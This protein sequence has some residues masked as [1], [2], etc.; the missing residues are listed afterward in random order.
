M[1]YQVPSGKWWR[2]TPEERIRKNTRTCQNGL[3]ESVFKTGCATNDDEEVGIFETERCDCT[4]VT[5][6]IIIIRCDCTQAK[7]ASATSAT[8]SGGV[9]IAAEG[10]GN[11]PVLIC[12][13]LLVIEI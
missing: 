3:Q 5:I 11:P 7:E 9:G 10:V 1:S 13:V 4:I 2:Y 6:V 12:F 8:S